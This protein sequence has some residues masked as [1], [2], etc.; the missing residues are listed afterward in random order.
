MCDDRKVIGFWISEKK[1]QKLNWSEFERVCAKNGFTLRMVD[2]NPNIKNQGRVD[3]FVHK[4]TNTLAIAEHGDQNAK[5]IISRIQEFIKKRSEMIVIDPLENVNNLQNRHKCYKIMRNALQ[6]DDVFAPNFVEFKST[7][8]E[9]NLSLLKRKNVKFP[10]LCKPLL[11]Q[12][13]TDAHKMMVIFNKDGLEDCQ[14]PCVAQDFINH[15]AI[16]YKLYVVGDKFH[17]VER[18]SLK[19]FYTKDCL[20]SNTI[21]FN[22][23]DISKC[24]SNSKL[25]IISD[26]DK[27]LTVKPNFET[28]QWIVRT[29]NKAFGLTLIGIDVVIENHTKKYAIIDVNIFPSYD[30]Y[31]HFFEQLIE[32]IK[33]LIDQKVARLNSNSNSNKC[34]SDDLDSGFESDEKRRSLKE[35]RLSN[36]TKNDSS[37]IP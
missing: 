31:P 32:C 36:D 30:G 5:T 8:I 16:L 12:G 28:F 25:S 26:E 14:V 13:S 29:I 27:N 21:F 4:L 33:K 19:N 3:V 34:L 18:P 22:S 37:A 11:A 20:T 35:L 23:S 15:N 6:H 7:N 1:R 9:E 10:F 24:D 2:L 17:V